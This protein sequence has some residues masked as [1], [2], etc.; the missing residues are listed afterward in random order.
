M[1]PQRTHSVRGFIGCPPWVLIGAVEDDGR[2]Q[3]TGGQLAALIAA[4]FFAVLSCVAMVVLSVVSVVC[5]AR[6]AAETS[7]VEA[8]CATSIFTGRL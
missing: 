4:G 6:A 2:A 3:M 7:T 1:R 8:T 5:T